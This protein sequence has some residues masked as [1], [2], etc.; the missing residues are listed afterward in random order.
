MDY[1]SSLHIKWLLVVALLLVT[2]PVCAESMGG[3]MVR[4]VPSVPPV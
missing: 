4:H 2:T 1:N 3:E